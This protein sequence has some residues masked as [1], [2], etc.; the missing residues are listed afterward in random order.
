[1]ADEQALRNFA[2]RADYS[3]ELHFVNLHVLNE[4][5]SPL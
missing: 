3:S 2:A 5:T 4:I 1:M